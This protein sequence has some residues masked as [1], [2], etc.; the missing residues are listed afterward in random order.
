MIDFIQNTIK[1]FLNKQNKKVDPAVIIEP[2]SGWQIIDFK[3]L[4]E[5]KDL[6]LFLVW[7]DIKAIYAQ[8]ILGFS[9]AI[10]QPLIQIVI[11][12]IVFGKVAKINTEGIHY[13]LFTTVAIIPWTYMSHAMTLSS[14]SLVTG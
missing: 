8:T 7:R 2:V 14:Q 1:R 3:E 4:K 5:Y 9:W 6:F 11:F 13:I 12:T 10:L